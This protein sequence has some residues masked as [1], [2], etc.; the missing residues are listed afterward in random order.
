MRVEW[1][2]GGAVGEVRVIYG[3][4]GTRQLEIWI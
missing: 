4:D 1:M 2:G 3:G